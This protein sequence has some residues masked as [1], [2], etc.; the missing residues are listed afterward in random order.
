MAKNINLNSAK[1]NKQDEFYT[2]IE[3]IDCEVKH[4]K[5]Y[6]KNKVIY[7]NCDTEKSNFVKY[8]IDN[9]NEFGIKKLI[10]TSFNNDGCGS[11]LIYEND[12]LNITSLKGNGDFRSEECIDL[13]ND[14]DVVITNPP[15]SLFREYIGQLLKHNKEFL[16]IGSLNAVAYK[17]LFPYIKNNEVRIGISGFKDMKFKVPNGY[18]AR[19]TRFWVDEFGQHWRSLGNACWF[20]N[21]NFIQNKPLELTQTYQEDIYPHYENYDGIEV[22]KLILIP[23]DY[24]GIMGVP[25]TYIG[26]HCPNQFDIVGL[27]STPIINGKKYYKRIL[28]RKKNAVS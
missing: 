5:Q 25:I 7:C 2:C 15:F 24:D 1:E 16:I 28:I 4:Y 20:T 3:D 11:L 14:C 18:E 26:K 12:K 21:I 8:F 22:S 6:L 10:A 23:K 17:D 19:L 9:F 27:A 13:L